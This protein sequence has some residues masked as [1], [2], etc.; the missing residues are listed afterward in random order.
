MLAAVCVF[1]II[2][3]IVSNANYES[4]EAVEFYPVETPSGTYAYI[5]VVLVSEWL[6]KSDSDTYYSVMDAD[7]CWYTVR[8]SDS[9]FAAMSTQY[10]YYENDDP[11]AP[12]PEAYRLYGMSAT[13]NSTLAE[14]MAEAWSLGGEN[15]YHSAFGD[16]YLNATSSP[17]S[18]AG[19]ILMLL[20]IFSGIISLI[21]LAIALPK[22]KAVKKSLAQLEALGLLDDAADQLAAPENINY[23]K[24]GLL[25][26][27]NYVFSRAGGVVL[28]YEDL[29][30]CFMRIQRTN[31]IKTGEFLIGN[32]AVCGSVSLA[33]NP[34][35]KKNAGTL[36][37]IMQQ[38]AQHNPQVLLGYTS[39]NIKAFNAHRKAAKQSARV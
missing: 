27:R 35:G 21:M 6:F 17:S 3:S 22:R 37:Q 9:Q 15:E 30:W 13:V 33:A 12:M 5:D 19:G 7:Q 10:E 4:P 34:I 29:F 11:S 38:I 18:D 24:Q 25:L 36:E 14:S 32:S 23:A 8:L 31:F 1:S 2:G 16:M 26:S 39:D 28:R 20:A